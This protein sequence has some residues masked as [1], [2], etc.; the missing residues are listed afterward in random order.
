[1]RSGKAK[2]KCALE[3]RLWVKET[4]RR[5]EHA[6]GLQGVVRRL[7]RF[8]LQELLPSEHPPAKG[9]SAGL[10]ED[11]IVQHNLRA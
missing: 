9:V 3:E 2:E 1:M 11:A 6:S 8:G 4:G 5:L 10:S 7:F